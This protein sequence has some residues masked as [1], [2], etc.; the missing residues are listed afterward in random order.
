M[1]ATATRTRRRPALRKLSFR[2]A[3]LQVVNYAVFMSIVWY[4]SFQPPYR[5]LS[6]GDAVVTLA[7]GHAAQRI[8]ECKKLSQEELNKLAPNMRK[9]EDCPRERSPVTIE[10]RLDGELAAR[11]VLE[12]PG[13]Y[14][15]QSV[16]VYKSVKVPHGRHSLS[17]W[18]N[19]DVNVEGPTFRFEDTIVLKPAQRLVVTFNQNEAGFSV[20]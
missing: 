4:F 20:N 6:E 18:M 7:F 2:S 12:A 17:V 15:D 19:D 8:G 11:E 13:L 1:Q 10:L 16:D 5:Q 9:P 14:R 3:L